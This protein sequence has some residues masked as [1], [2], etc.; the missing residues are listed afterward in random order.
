[1]R[2]G[3]NG[4]RPKYIIVTSR[5]VRS[6]GGR[7]E[8]RIRIIG[9]RRSGRRRLLAHPL[10]LS[11]MTHEALR[12]AAWA[13]AARSSQSPRS[14]GRGSSTALHLTV[15]S[16][17]S[18]RVRFSRRLPLLVPQSSPPADHAETSDSAE[19]TPLMS[20]KDLPK[21]DSVIE[22]CSRLIAVRSRSPSLPH[23]GEGAHI[24]TPLANLLRGPHPHSCN[25]PSLTAAAR[26]P[27]RRNGSP[28]RPTK[29]G[30]L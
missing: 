4:S 7:C 5:I 9:Q 10:A 21:A 18:S 12:I 3:C 20:S 28:F 8:G 11:P 24:P 1:M 27:L 30:G 19:C 13:A 6:A 22:A 15:F 23:C 17:P 2:F 26:C 14:R 29:T 25:K 16:R